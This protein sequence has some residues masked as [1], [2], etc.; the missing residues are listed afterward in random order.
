MLHSFGT[1]KRCE[2]ARSC[3]HVSSMSKMTGPL[4]RTKAV[5]EQLTGH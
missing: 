1:R 4:M 5:V 3:C 2:D